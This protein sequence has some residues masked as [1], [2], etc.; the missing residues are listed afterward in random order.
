VAESVWQR[1]GC[2]QQVDVMTGADGSHSRGRGGPKSGRAESLGARPPVRPAS[3]AAIKTQY[4][5]C[6]K[7]GHFQRANVNGRVKKPKLDT[8]CA[9]MKDLFAYC[10]E[11]NFREVRA[12]VVHYPYLLSLTDAHGFS[13]LHHAAMSSDPNF[14]SQ[15]LQ[16][17]RDPKTFSLKVITYETEE[18]LLSDLE[19]GFHVTSVVVGSQTEAKVLSVG[20]GSKAEEAGVMP[21][22]VL[23]ACSGTGFLSY[24]QTPT[25]AEDVLSTLRSDRSTSFGFPVSLDFRGNA[26]VEIL[27]K[28]GFTPSHG[29]AGRGGPA[30]HKVLMHLLSEEDRAQLAQDMTGC[31]PGHWLHIAHRASAHANRRPLSAG[32]RGHGANRR[33]TGLK[34]EAEPIMACGRVNSRPS[35][36][37]K[38]L[39]KA[40]APAADARVEKIHSAVPV[41]MSSAPVMSRPVTPADLVEKINNSRGPTAKELAAL[42]QGGQDIGMPETLVAAASHAL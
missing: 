26:A 18:E 23:E 35:T 1:L 3:A 9:K 30:D 12:M 21:G 24:R 17:Y 19:L 22:D 28:D 25:V 39:A 32:P 33:Q 6:G 29:A 37:K 36:A 10:R 5:I 31:T 38:S 11:G 40:S 34:L 4:P 7:V 42:M 16:L 14:M 41:I 20:Q 8:D 15:V 2:H 27:G 13:A